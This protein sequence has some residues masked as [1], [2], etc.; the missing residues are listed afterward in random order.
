MKV[1]RDLGLLIVMRPLKR[2]LRRGKILGT[3]GLREIDYFS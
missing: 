3:I 1:R 2:A